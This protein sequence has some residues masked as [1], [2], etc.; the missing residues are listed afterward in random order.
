M[1]KKYFKANFHICENCNYHCNHCF[2]K[3]GKPHTLS[4]EQWKKITDNVISSGLIN[5]VNIAGGEPF[6]HIEFIEIV[7][8]IRSLDIPVS[9]ITNGYFMTE[10]WIRKYAGLFRTIGFSIDSFQPDIL[11]S[12]GRCTSKNQFISEQDFN[13][14]IFILKEVNPDINIKI[15]TVVSSLNVLDCLSAYIDY[16]Y[17]KRWKILKM[18]IFDDGIH[19]N[20]DISINDA[21]YN[22]YI[23]NSFEVLGLEFQSEKTLYKFNNTEIVT[24]RSLKGGYI[25]IGADG[26]LLDDTLN[27]SY[28]KVCDCLTE[29]FSVGIEKL[30][31]NKSLYLSR[32]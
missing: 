15:N 4:A 17:I 19:C 27:L 14:K 26:C 6:L 16:R 11:K 7:K 25:M 13:R 9:L 8:Y 24:E 3:F 23:K 5:E 21:Q 12:I 20:S 32:Y 22:N 2:A 31:F 10:E 29:S 18:Q 28:T 1:T 30:N